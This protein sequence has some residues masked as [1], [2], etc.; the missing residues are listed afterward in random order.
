[1]N[2]IRVPRDCIDNRYLFTHK[3]V[4]VLGLKE[5]YNDQK[6]DLIYIDMG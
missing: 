5:T 1:M 3:T 2:Q 6:A 4:S